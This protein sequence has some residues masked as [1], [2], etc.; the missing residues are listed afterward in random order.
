MRT[1]IIQNKV[2]AD[3]G[4]G[5]MSE[6]WADFTTVYGYIDLVT[7]TNQNTAQNAII[8]QSTHLIILPEYIDI[9][10]D[11]MRIIDTSGRWYAIT[12]VDDPMGLQHH[13]EVYC[14]WGGVI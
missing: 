7:G 9:L 6:T 13:L 3:D 12:Y 14:R 11:Q 4:I 10:T 1:L 8:E 2:Q 5:G